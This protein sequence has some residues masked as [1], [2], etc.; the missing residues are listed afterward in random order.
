MSGHFGARR[1]S[2][3]RGGPPPGRI[4]YIEAGSGPVALF[5]HGR[6]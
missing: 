3:N 2:V 6:C 1:L 4:S 5:V